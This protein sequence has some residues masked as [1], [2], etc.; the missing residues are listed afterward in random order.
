MKIK[1]TLEKVNEA[2]L[3]IGAITKGQSGNVYSIEG[4]S[5][6]LCANGGGNGAKTGLYDVKDTLRK[7][8]PIECERLQGL[9][10]GYTE[11]VSNTQRYKALGNGF[12]VDVICHILK[13]IG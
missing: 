1:T 5:S 12:N 3:K 4:K 13:Y 9:P 8:H 10:D 6:P 11:G 2:L 7:L